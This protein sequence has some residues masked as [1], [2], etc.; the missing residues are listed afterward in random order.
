[1][2]R[3]GREHDH[4]DV[5]A[6]ASWR[7]TVFTDSEWFADAAERQ[8]E[9]S[10]I[11]AIPGICLR[12]FEIDLMHAADLGIT[13]A[14]I[15]SALHEV[16]RELGGNKAT[17]VRVCAELQKLVALHARELQQPGP[18]VNSFPVSWFSFRNR[19]PKLKAKASECRRLLPCV[20]K[21]LESLPLD[22]PHKVLRLHCLR[23]APALQRR[24]EGRGQER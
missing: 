19:V 4:G 9:L 21:L 7:P 24:G 17:A 8:Q 22:T 5:S 16:F 13:G 14:A 18:P 3:A 2:C 12:S 15:A 23:W 1:M 20:V 11:W 6:A 10:K